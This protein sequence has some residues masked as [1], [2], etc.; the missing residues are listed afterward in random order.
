MKVRDKG[1]RMAGAALIA[2]FIL[3]A[4]LL[5]SGCA[6]SAEKKAALDRKAAAKAEISGLESD[7][8]GVSDE[9]ARIDLLREI[10]R[11]EVMGLGDLAPAIKRY[12][13]NEGLLSR[14][15]MSRVFIAVAQSMTAGREKKIENKLK[16]LMR[17]MGSFEALREEFPDEAMVYLYQASTYANFPPEVGAKAEVLDILAEMR[18]RFASGDWDPSGGFSGQL[19]YVFAAL[20]RNYPDASSLEE[21][22]AGRAEFAAADPEFAALAA[23]AGKK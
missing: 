13:E 20:E 18:G 1:F 16:W 9:A 17:G 7:L 21:I 23:E 15:P 3:C 12:A 8:R 14:D 4:A 6:M 19:E 22:R 2:S 5:V 11:I 10:L